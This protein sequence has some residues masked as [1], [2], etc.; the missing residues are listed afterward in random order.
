MKFALCQELLEGWEWERQCRFIAQC[1]YTG[2][3][4]APF[5]LAPLITDVP[6]HRR[7]ELRKVAEEFGL[8]ICG[9]HWLLART[10]GF[11]LT[12]DDASVRRATSA[13]LTS[14]TQA[15]ADLGGNI[16]VL[17]SPQQR[18]R[19][20]GVSKEEA[21]SRAAE[22]LRAVTP[23][24]EARQVT[25]ALEPL[26]TK[27][28]NF[29]NTCAE[30][31]QLAEVV[32]SAHVRLHQDVKAMLSEETSIPDLITRYAAHTAHFHA[33]DDNLLGPG[34]G[35]TD[36]HPIFAALRKVSY[37]GWVS[38]EVF[39]YSPGA[40]HVAQESIEYM[41]RVWS[42]VCSSD[43]QGPSQSRTE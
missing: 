27:E 38:V 3:E 26:T 21:M 4:L 15:C 31:V 16:L 10:S 12:T 30:A 7:L 40:E 14:L 39:D 28:T 23:S 9:L 29:L 17:G 32:G 8:T 37:A 5:T 24:L 2:I 33:N 1:G 22:V 13:Y 11:H 36:Y 41:Q 6:A 35:R 18:N 34:M 43:T 42:A 19:A 20:E 25:L